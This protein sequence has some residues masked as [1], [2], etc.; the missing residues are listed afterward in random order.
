MKYVLLRPDI[1]S[2]SGD[3]VPASGPCDRSELKG[4]VALPQ[5][6]WIISA[7]LIHCRKTRSRASLRPTRDE[8]GSRRPALLRTSCYLTLRGKRLLMKA[9]T[10]IGVAAVIFR[11]TCAA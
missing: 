10:L 4:S 2:I 7:L 3:D 11:L 6:E 5:S 8:H 9:L 1:A